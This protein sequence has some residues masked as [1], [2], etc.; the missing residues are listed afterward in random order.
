MY[1]ASPGPII[2]PGAA[3]DQV[4][5]LTN[6]ELTALGGPELI[7]VGAF[8]WTLPEAPDLKAGLPARWTSVSGTDDG[9][10]FCSGWCTNDLCAMD[11]L[12]LMG[13]ADMVAFDS[14][15]D[16]APP[17]PLPPDEREPWM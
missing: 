9:A 6:P 14:R 11:C 15:Y 5:T 12:D 4:P 17:Q 10:I 8:G 7:R 1:E 16:L 3:L 2:V 13:H